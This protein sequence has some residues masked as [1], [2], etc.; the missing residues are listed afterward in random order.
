MRHFRIERFSRCKL[1]E[2]RR[3]KFEAITVSMLFWIYGY[4]ISPYILWWTF[5]NVGVLR[6]LQSPF[7]IVCA[8]HFYL[9]IWV[10]RWNFD[11]LSLGMHFQYEIG[12]I[13]CNLYLKC[14]LRRRKGSKYM[15]LVKCRCE[16]LHFLRQRSK[17][18]SNLYGTSTDLIRKQ[19]HFGC[20]LYSMCLRR[21]PAFSDITFI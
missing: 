20:W 4:S 13:I 1:C 3:K 6:Y 11:L 10:Y 5:V 2:S 8:Q 12:I 19:K 14:I 21:S 15:F 16:L 7:R 9:S 17:I 18:N